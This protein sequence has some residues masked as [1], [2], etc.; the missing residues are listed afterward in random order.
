V[1]IEVLFMALSLGH[2]PGLRVLVAA[3]KEKVHIRIQLREL[4]D[5]GTAPENAMVN[6]WFPGAVHRI[7]N[8]P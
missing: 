2:S 5:L 7:L 4:N 1:N 8:V 3:T 6:E